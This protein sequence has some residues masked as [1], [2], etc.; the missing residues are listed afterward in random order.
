MG[1]ARVKRCWLVV[2]RCARNGQS[3]CVTYTL[4][5]QAEHAAAILKQAKLRKKPLEKG[6]W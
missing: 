4:D 6:Q 1:A 5:E 2:L 3:Y